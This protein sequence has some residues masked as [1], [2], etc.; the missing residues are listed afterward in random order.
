[1]QDSPHSSFLKL[2]KTNVTLTEDEVIYTAVQMYFEL[3]KISQS[4]KIVQQNLT[5]VNTLIQQAE[6]FYRPWHCY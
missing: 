3:Y 6:Q 1:M 2:R 4:Q 5:A